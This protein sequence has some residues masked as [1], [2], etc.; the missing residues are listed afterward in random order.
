MRRE[1][2][3]LKN[4]TGKDISNS[5]AM[6]V[7]ILIALLFVYQAV[8]FVVHKIRKAAYM[9]DDGALPAMVAGNGAV[10]AGSDAVAGPAGTLSGIMRFS[11]NP[12]T[13]SKD[14]LQL[15]GF[16]YRQAQSIINYRNKGGKFRKKGDFARLYVVDSTMYLSLR[17]YILLP[18]NH[19]PQSKTASAVSASH[20][21][22]KGKSQNAPT[23]TSTNTSTSAPPSVP[24][25]GGN[26]GTRDAAG[27]NVPGSSESTYRGGNVYGT[28]VERNRYVCNLNT[29]D[30]AALVELYGIGGYYAKR[31]LE[32]RERLGGSF[33]DKRQLLEIEGFSQERFS[34][35][36]DHIEVRK[37]QV[38]GFSILGADRKALERHPYIGAYAARGVLLY[39][40][41]KGKESFN[42]ELQLLD[43]LVKERILS[44]NNAQRLREY[45]LH[46]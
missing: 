32:Y 21:G 5:R 26:S 1:N 13:V 27:Q 38:K 14:S 18:D 11:F 30:S 31:I 9:G 7:I 19:L 36:E 16:S 39:I 10:P 25:S 37:D 8:T 23:N 29:A 45:L 17:E 35:I 41:L 46:L 6:G 20:P 34:K 12:N 33:A 15:L 2:S 43:E 24:S 22:E 42:D 4:S 44:E 40:R 28:R 3:Q